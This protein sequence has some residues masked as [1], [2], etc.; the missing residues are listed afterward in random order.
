MTERMRAFIARCDQKGWVCP[1]PVHWDSFWNLLP[2][3][4]NS[5]R[6][7]RPPAPR[8]L[9]GWVFSDDNQ[10]RARFLE[11]LAWADERGVADSAL[12]FLESLSPTDWH[13]A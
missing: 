8:I 6:H 9:N 3:N 12:N 13:R 5:D 11:H 7:S 4:S 1:N 10:K 2:N